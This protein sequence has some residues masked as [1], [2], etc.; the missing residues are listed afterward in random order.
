[1]SKFIVEEKLYD[2]EKST[3]IATGTKAWEEYNIIFGR[4]VEYSRE[5]ELYK[6]PKGTFFFVGKRNGSF[7]IMTVT[8]EEEAKKWLMRASLSKYEEMYGDLERG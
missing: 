8:T 7:N 2:T 5:T 3:L 4:N 6:S 1:M